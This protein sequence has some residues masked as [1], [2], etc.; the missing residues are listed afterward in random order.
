MIYAFFL[1]TSTFSG[2]QLKRKIRSRCTSSHL[3]HVYSKTKGGQSA[4]EDG[5]LYFS[6]A[7]TPI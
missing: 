7:V 6:N 2:T 4:M 5:M 1:F 3:F